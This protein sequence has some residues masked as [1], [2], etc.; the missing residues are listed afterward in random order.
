MDVTTW[1]TRET[2]DPAFTAAWNARIARTP[3]AHHA[4]RPDFLAW[5]A[6]HGRT[7]LAV[8]VEEPAG[9][10][11]LRRVRGGWSSGWMWRTQVAVESPPPG[12]LA[13][14]DAQ[15]RG[16]LAAVDAVSQGTLTRCYLPHAAGEGEPAFEASTT[17][18]HGL[19][20]TE[21]AL[22][23]TFDGNRRRAVKKAAKEGFAIVS[24][25]TFDHYRGF[26]AI[27]VETARRRGLQ[28]GPVPDTVE[29]SGESWREWELPWMRLL[30]AVRDGRVHAGS[31]F[32][33]LPGGTVEYRANASS[34]EARAAGVNVALAWEGLRMAQADGAK[35]LNWG[36]ATEFKKNLGGQRVAIWCRLG[37]G[38]VWALPN[39]VALSWHR[40]RP[41]LAGLWH[42]LARRSA[43]S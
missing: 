26:A 25:T 42:S 20:C 23:A 14:T 5:D 8:L 9:M 6:R 4:L 31:G 41:R 39:Q 43:A 1:D 12:P 28:T 17:Y 21:D 13:L 7:A 16:L 22:F 36:G 19:E 33:M 3:Q 2:P 10:L 27:Q 37:G 32:G 40:V 34:P 11:V 24:A 29:E 18:V 30:V 15:R 35:W 38:P